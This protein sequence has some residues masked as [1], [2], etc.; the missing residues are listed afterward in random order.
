MLSGTNLDHPPRK[1][2]DTG[3]GLD[4]PDPLKT[5]EKRRGCPCATDRIDCCGMAW[6]D[7]CPRL[8]R[9]LYRHSRS[10][11]DGRNSSAPDCRGTCSRPGLEGSGETAEPV[12]VGAES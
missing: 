12:L 5:L 11:M 7:G 6:D 2:P 9:L 10:V 8:Y 1:T 3:K 4:E